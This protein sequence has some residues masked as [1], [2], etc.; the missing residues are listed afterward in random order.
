MVHSS[1]TVYAL[2]DNPNRGIWRSTDNGDTWVDHSPAVFASDSKG[3]TNLKLGPDGSIY[4]LAYSN[5]YRTSDNGA[6][7]TKLNSVSGSENGGFDQGVELAV[8]PLSGVIYVFGYHY[9][10]SRWTVFRSANNGSTWTKGEQDVY[11]TQLVSNSIGDVYGLSGSELWKSTDNASNFIQL[12]TPVPTDISGGT[13]YITVKPD[14]TQIAVVTSSDNIYTLTS[15]STTWTAVTETGI[16]DATYSANGMLMYTADNSMLFLFDN[17][18]NKVYSRTTGSWTPKATGFV[19]TIGEDAISAT[20]LNNN[21][22]YVGTER[23]G[24]YKSINSGLGWSEANTGIENHSM[25]NM[26]IADNGAIIVAGSAVFRSTDEGQ[27]WTKFTAA[28]CSYYTVMKAS[29]GSPKTILLLAENGG[30]S[31]KSD[32]D[33]ADWTAIANTPGATNFA[34]PDGTRIIAYNST[35][36]FYS[37]DQG[38]TWTAPLTMSGFPSSYGFLAYNNNSLAMDHNRVIYSAVYDY[39]AQTTKFFRI[40]L[41]PAAPSIPTTATATEISFATMGMGNFVDAVKF[42]NNKIYVFGQPMSG[43]NQVVTSTANAGVNWTA[44]AAPQSDRFDVDPLNNYLFVTRSN[45]S[46]YTIH[47][48]RDDGTSWTPTSVNLS[49]SNTSGYG[50]VLNTN[51]IGYAGFNGSSVHKTTA[52]IVTPAAPTGLTLAGRSTNKVGL[53]WNDNATNEANYI[54][55]KFNGVDYDS[56]GRTFDFFH[57]GGKGFFEVP[58]LQPNTAYQFRIYARNAAG[59]SGAVTINASTLQ[60]CTSTIPDNKSWNGNVNGSVTLTNVTVKKVAD[61]VYS[62]SDIN[63]GAYASYTT[64][65]GIVEYGC[66]GED[67]QLYL[68]R[69][70]PFVA[71]GN[72]TWNS[73]TNTLV[74]TWITDPDISSAMTGTVTLVKNLSDPPPVAPAGLSAYNYSNNSIELKWQSTGF[75]NKFYIERKLGAGGVYAQ[76]GT[77]DY[78]AVSFIDNTGLVTGQT[79]FYRVKSENGNVVPDASPYSNEIQIVFQ[80]PN[81]VVAQTTVNATP[82]NSL[83]SVWSDFN[84]DGFDDLLLTKFDLTSPSIPPLFRSDGAGDFVQVSPSFESAIYANATTADFDNDGDIDIFYSTFGSSLQRLYSGNGGFAFTKISPSPVE[85]QP[86][87]DIDGGAAF[88]ASWIDYDRDGLID[89][90]V[91]SNGDY[92]G[93]LF[94]QNANH[95]FTKV[96]TAGEIV[97]SVLEAFDCSWSDYDNDGDPDLFIIDQASGQPN[98]LFRNNNDGTFTRVIGSAFDADA[99]S[100]AQSVAWADFDNDQD[101][102]LFVGDEDGANILY[103]NN[104]NGTFTKLTTPSF[105]VTTTNAFGS[106]WA[107]I[108]NDGFI[109]LIVV[110]IGGSSSLFINSNGTSF[111]KINTEKL[112]DATLFNLSSSV[113]DFNNDGF[114]DLFVSSSTLQGE[115]QVGVPQS[116]FLLK[117]NN[118]TGNWL[119]IKLTGTTSNRSAIGARIRV[120]TGAV[121]QIRDVSAH[122]GICSQNSL[123]QHFGLGTSTVAN[124]TITWPSGIIQTLTN[125]AV[126]TTL[127]ITEDGAGPAIVTQTPASTST[128]VAANT[129]ISFTL[130]ETSTPQPGK[131]LQ[132][133]LQ[134]DLTTPIFGIAVT[135][136]VKSGNTYTFTLPNKLLTATQYNISV[137]AGAFLDSFG[138]ASLQFPTSSWTF[139]VAPGPINTNF[140]PAHN[141][142]GVAANSALQLT[143]DKNIAAVPGKR[144]KVL[145][146]ATTVVDVDVA[147]AG[148][149]TNN[150]YSLTPEA[151]LPTDKELKVTVDA[152]AFIDAQAQTDFAGIPLDSWVFRTALSAD[153]TPPLITFVPPLTAAKGFN[154]LVSPEITVTDDRGTVSSVVINIKKITAA[155]SSAVEVP[156][157]QGTGSNAGKWVFSISEANHFDAI[158]TEYFI[159][160]KDPANNSVRNPATGTHKL[161]LTY[162][163]NESKIPSDKLGF[164]GTVSNWKVF[165][166]PFNLGSNNSVTAI[167]NELEGQT[168]KIDYR[169]LT[170]QSPGNTDW[171]EYPTFS[172]INRGQGYFSNI[173]TPVDILLGSLQA[174][175][176]SRSNLFTINLKAGWNMVG[177]PYLTQISWADVKTF[178]ALTGQVAEL[179]KF[180]GSTYP[181]GVQTL[182]P[183]EGGFV[184]AQSD[185]TVTIPFLNQTASGGRWG[186][187]TLGDD[188]NNSEWLLQLNVQ[189]GGV[190]NDLGS[191]GMSPDA[192][193]SL[194]DYDGVTPPRFIDYLE[195]NFAH[196]EH[197]AKRFSRDVVPTLNE[198]TWSFTVDTNL[199]GEAEIF[200]NNSAFKHGAKEIFLFDEARQKLVDMRTVSRYSFNPKESAKF[201]VYFG[202]NLKIAP[203]T[204]LLGKAFPNPSSGFTTIAFSLPDSGGQNQVVTLEILDA[205]GK[206]IGTLAQGRYQP[207]FY[208]TGFNARELN[209][210]FYTY[211][212]TVQSS[213]GRNTLVSKLIIK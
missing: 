71:N 102:D 173:K 124:V 140:S 10:D 156:A 68:Q 63:N 192:K 200:W 184:F 19:T 14:G 1:G 21:T 182:D 128:N 59:I 49:T 51:G 96:T 148:T 145:D 189:Q 166:I 139:T 208:E 23:A 202:E 94:K 187:Q 9:P 179:H 93:R 84:N 180:N 169:F 3:L 33:G 142:T 99:A 150:V 65:A 178:N 100:D 13:N 110:G 153:I 67:P 211:R 41:T 4:A 28:C 46:A 74:L 117:N 134:T 12:T 72:G 7:W 17:Q 159:T 111:T 133:Y 146:G 212:L 20:S 161:Y 75:E 104:G 48:S 98:K 16:A 87:G 116:A 55:E 123:T 152:G 32:N 27:S 50:V 190:V 38:A 181:V 64:R 101:M 107:D 163:A 183:Y 60:T 34:S 135:D 54:I 5:L 89:L 191:I 24:V 213:Q 143:F 11:F 70:Y 112:S 108:N 126:N 30:V 97:S 149:V 164:G 36:L 44:K 80:K 177:N 82:F 129:V 205:T 57:P 125:V 29:T 69:D 157:I 198:Y 176:N 78:P 193:L 90:Y 62:I 103:R 121:N 81:F 39:D 207:G 118:T 174:P 210:G 155:A 154:N 197:F 206:H 160:A 186:Y 195:M 26:V 88:A 147:D 144:L 136:A 31:Y 141:A 2:G 115:G 172:T 151:D 58:N 194:D 170:I 127:N 76:V 209:N 109:D 40:A 130:N 131:M 171:T 95:T 66:A 175:E 73:S 35:Q 203:Q 119:K 162:T 132:L 37:G 79:Y 77:V 22:L 122:I 168:N 85:E 201:K 106:N 114:P 25:R 138:N 185:V 83:G 15:P 42:L 188:I 86:S 158:G 56:I 18:N 113:G 199:D 120:T 204:V 196:P 6:T 91:A 45:S 47:I 53:T 8:N 92:P 61:G 52:T 167:F 165:S 43:S 105:D 137:D